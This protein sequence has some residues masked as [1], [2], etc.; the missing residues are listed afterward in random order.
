MEDLAVHAKS[1]EVASSLAEDHRPKQDD[2]VE[3]VDT[4]KP[5]KAG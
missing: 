4:V 5:L 2:H 1:D 3:V